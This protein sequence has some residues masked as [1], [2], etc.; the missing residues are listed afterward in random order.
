MISQCVYHPS[1]STRSLTN[2]QL[3]HAAKIQKHHGKP[4]RTASNLLFLVSQR[5][6][7]FEDLKTSPP[8]EFLGPTSYS[9]VFRENQAN[10]GEDILNIHPEDESG[11]DDFVPLVTSEQDQWKKSE[12]LSLAISVLGNFPNQP[13][14]ERLL[15]RFFELSFVE[16][17]HEPTIRYAYDKLW[18]EFGRYITK[19]REPKLLSI[20]AEKM[21][22]NELVP[23]PSCRSTKEWLES[24]TGPKLRWETLGTFFACFGLAVMT[25]SDWDPMFPYEAADQKRDKRQYA[26]KLGECAEACLVLCEDSGSSNEFA[27]WLTLQIHTLQFVYSGDECRLS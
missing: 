17:L 19:P 15:N 13:L 18:L 7:G 24:F 8:V 5:S 14:S 27:V 12:R 25:M 1:P 6:A 4:S 26:H 10:I 2:D 3:V 20:V 9:A 21:L 11:R 22:Q 16:Y 23:L